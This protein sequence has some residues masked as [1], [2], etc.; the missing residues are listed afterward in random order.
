MPRAYQPRTS[1]LELARSIRAL[2]GIG[3][4]DILPPYTLAGVR[5]PARIKVTLTATAA[6]M[7]VSTVF[8]LSEARQ[9]LALEQR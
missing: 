4:V 7:P 3:R 5:H 8:T 6:Y 1:T 9:W 2:D